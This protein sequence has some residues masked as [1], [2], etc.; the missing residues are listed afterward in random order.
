MQMFYFF[1]SSGKIE[2]KYRK[3]RRGKEATGAFGARTRN[4]S[5]M[6]NLQS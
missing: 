6:E 2:M 3:E 5:V 1:R 4:N